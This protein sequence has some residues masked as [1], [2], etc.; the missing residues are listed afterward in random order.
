MTTIKADYQGQKVYLLK[1][2]G[3]FETKSDLLKF[4]K[5]NKQK[6]EKG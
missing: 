5:N 1:E 2:S 6:V 4:V 3:T